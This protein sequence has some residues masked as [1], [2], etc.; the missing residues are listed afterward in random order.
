MDRPYMTEWFPLWSATFRGAPLLLFL[1]SVLVAGYTL[2]RG[3]GWKRLPGLPMVLVAALFALQSVRILPIYVV[4]WFSYV[5]P[6]LSSTPVVPV[7]RRLWHRH[8]RPVAA[9]TLIISTVGLARILH[10]EALAVFLPVEGRDHRQLFPAGA[11]Q[12]LAEIDFHGNLMTPFGVGA[13][14]SWKLHP[15]VRVGM[16]SRYEVAY[17]PALAEETMRVYRGEGDWREFLAR[18]P[19]DAVLVPSS[20]AL[21]SLIVGWTREEGSRPDPPDWPAPPDRPAPPGWREPP[22]WPD[23][24]EWIEVFRDDAYAIFARPGVAAGMPRVDRTG[25]PIR[26]SFP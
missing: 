12:Y 17:D 25:Q 16:D 3:A 11:V 20:G 5:S 19:T 22:G 24:P 23:P 10:Q 13:Y 1:A 18:H 21:D 9:L 2:W 15:Q 4:V 7:V 14:V 8:A 26:G 6:A